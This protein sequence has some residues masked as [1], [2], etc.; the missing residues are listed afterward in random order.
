[1]LGESRN[2]NSQDQLI[3]KNCVVGTSTRT[4][5]YYDSVIAKAD[6]VKLLAYLLVLPYVLI[7]YAGLPTISA[8]FP[9][10]LLSTTFT[11]VL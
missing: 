5:C 11:L 4:E 10:I 1:M 2:T 8:S 3:S 7:I 6:V 9:N